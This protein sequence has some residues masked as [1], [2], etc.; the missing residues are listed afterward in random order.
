MLA[1][2]AFTALVIYLGRARDEPDLFGLKRVIAVALF[3]ALT[4]LIIVVVSAGDTLR[5][6]ENLGTSATR[7]ACA[8]GTGCCR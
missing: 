5:R 3:F 6:Q 8:C 2:S 1:G 4:S 7:P